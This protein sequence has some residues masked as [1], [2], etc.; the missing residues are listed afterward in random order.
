MRRGGEASDD[1]AAPIGAY[2]INAKTL[3]HSL[4][5]VGNAHQLGAIRPCSRAATTWFAGD[6]VGYD[7]IGV[8]AVIR[9]WGQRMALIG[10]T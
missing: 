1:P 4:R 7:I 5:S 8:H 6:N 10:S 9:E 3:H 2:S